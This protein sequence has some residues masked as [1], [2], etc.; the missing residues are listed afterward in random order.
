MKFFTT[1]LS[2]FFSI[3]CFACDICGN[4]MGITP[5][6]NQSQLTLLHRYRVFNG[7]RSYQQ[8]SAFFIPGA[9]KTQ[10]D[11]GA[12]ANDSVIEIKEH[13][14]K[15]YESFKVIELRGKYFLHPRLELNFILPVQQIK[16]SYNGLQN[17][18][19][20]LA[21]PSIFLAWHLIRKLDPT[22]LR[23]RLILGIGV[24]APLGND[25]ARSKSGERLFLLTQNGTGS[26]DGF[27]Y[28][29]YIVSGRYF[30]VSTNSLF[31]FNS[32][33]KFHEKYAKSFAQTLSLFIKLEW[34]D[35]RMIPALLVNYEYSK[36]LF[37]NDKL[38]EDTKMNLLMLGP[39]LDLSYQNL[40][41]NV[42]YQFNSYERVSSQSLSSSGRLIIGL[43]WNFN[44]KKYLIN[45]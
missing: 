40:V 18:N 8:R 3:S 38:T 42:A 11:P 17:T 9:Y 31:K 7:Y 22:A 36:G 20:G 45:S 16:T 14:V 24:K 29:N 27:W 25:A 10:H 41:L 19:T 21:D 4:F 44:Q 12:S 37:I 43:T 5:Y 32:E 1:T 26:W 2:L 33:N 13:S 30:G 23:Q 39:S 35:F 6:D 28:L 15:D 34:D